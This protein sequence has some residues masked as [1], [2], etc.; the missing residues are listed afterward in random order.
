M[1]RLL[2]IIVALTFATVNFAAK[3]A[4]AEGVDVLSVPEDIMVTGT[5]K[6]ENGPLETVNVVVKDQDGKIR[7]HAVTDING[8][9]VLRCSKDNKIIEF[10]YVGCKTVTLKLKKKNYKIKMKADPNIKMLDV[11]ANKMIK[12]Y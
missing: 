6:G 3:N 10:S 11:E 1:K 2:T 5:V 8:D 12:S 7:A 4:N 9:F